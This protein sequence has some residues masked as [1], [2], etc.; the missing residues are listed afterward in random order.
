VSDL[1][2]KIENCLKIQFF[3]TLK[4]KSDNFDL[5]KPSVRV[6]FCKK[7]LKDSKYKGFNDGNQSIYPFFE[8]NE[9]RTMNK[10]LSFLEEDLFIPQSIRMTI[11][12]RFLAVSFF[13]RRSEDEKSLFSE[14][15]EKVIYS[16]NESLKKGLKNLSRIQLDNISHC[17]ENELLTITSKDS[18]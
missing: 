4:F 15:F 3:N 8:L 1:I 13:E 6:S 12:R 7:W 5:T 16:Y 18:L 9:Q 11:V 17:V 10:I 14:D 2:V